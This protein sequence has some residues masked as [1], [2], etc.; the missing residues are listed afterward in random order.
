[1]LQLKN[2]QINTIN[3]VDPTSKLM[4]E[5]TGSIFKM[6]GTQKKEF[7]PDDMIWTIDG[8][9]INDINKS[10]S[11]EHSR[12]ISNTNVDNIILQ[13][14][15]VYSN[16]KNPKIYASTIK[17]I[18]TIDEQNSKNK[19]VDYFMYSSELHIDENNQFEIYDISEKIDKLNYLDVEILDENITL[20]IMKK[21]TMFK[22]NKNPMTFRNILSVLT[23]KFVQ[24]YDPSYINKILSFVS[25][26]WKSIESLSIHKDNII[27]NTENETIESNT[28]ISTENETIESNT[29]ISTEN[30]TIESYNDAVVIEDINLENINI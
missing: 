24:I 7:K 22:Q 3:E 2:V 4:I 16:K 6:I 28:D 8:M 29:D 27:T 25:D 20:D 30:E 1:M 18:V 11:L 13:Y 5:S 26:C 19:I 12:I 14:D 23:E 17:K 10:T 15:I 21:F 9:K